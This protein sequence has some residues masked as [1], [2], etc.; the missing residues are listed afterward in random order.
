M[1]AGWVLS[2]FADEAGES[3]GEQLAALRKAGLDWIDLRNVDGYNVSDLP[4]ADARRLR[5]RLD[6]AGVRVGMLGSPIGKCS[7]DCNL[8]EDLGKLRH[9]AAV[10]NI[11]GCG[12]VR[13]FS[14]YNSK[15]E[16]LQEEGWRA[17]AVQRLRALKKEASRLGM[18]LYLENEG[19]LFGDTVERVQSLLR[20]LRDE[21]EGARIF[22]SIFDFDNY[23][24]VGEDVWKAWQTLR[25]VTDAFHLKESRHTPTNGFEHVPLGQGEVNSLK[26]LQDAKQR[27]FKGSLSLEPHLT[28]SPA[29]LKTGPHGRAN[30]NLDS[31]GAAGTFQIAA[32]AAW[33]VLGSVSSFSS[34]RV[35]NV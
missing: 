27:G 17:E 25:D 9:L 32:E 23:L 35:T 3:A 28:R 6:A 26:I 29:V 12:S 4:L 1:P 20:E 16:P 13:I 15:A 21:D 10:G 18:T 22:G 7:L 14:Y 31:I 8:E 24:Q 19:G 33:E 30:V 11:I 2:A 5:Q 34:A